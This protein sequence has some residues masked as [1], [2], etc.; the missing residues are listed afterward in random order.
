MLFESL[1]D[2]VR[3]AEYLREAPAA[4]PVRAMRSLAADALESGEP[5]RERLVRLAFLFVAVYTLT[6]PTDCATASPSLNLM[7][8]PLHRDRAL[9]E[10]I[11]AQI[12]PRLSRTH[13]EFLAV[14]VSKAS[15]F[16]ATPDRERWTLPEWVTDP[17]A[18]EFALS[19]LVAYNEHALRAACERVEL[20]GNMLR[21][22]DSPIE[23]ADTAD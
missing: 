11:L 22:T 8:P 16:F 23:Q 1:T 12:I 17:A 18:A 5:E 3:A 10:S 9:V 6:D 13:R 4:L 2:C 21:I 15:A 7:P 19:S 14:S 20:T